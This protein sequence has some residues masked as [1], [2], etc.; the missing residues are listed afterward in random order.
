MLRTSAGILAIVAASFRWW[1][2]SQR[3][4]SRRFT[5][6]AFH[7][8]TIWNQGAELLNSEFAVS[9]LARTTA[10]RSSQWPP[11]FSCFGFFVLL[12]QWLHGGESIG[13][14]WI[15]GGFES[16]VWLCSL[17]PVLLI[18]W[19]LLLLSDQKGVTLPPVTKTP[20]L[21]CC[22][23]RDKVHMVSVDVSSKKIS[24]GS[25]PWWRHFPGSNAFYSFVS[26]LS[27]VVVICSSLW[28]GWTSKLGGKRS[29]LFL[30]SW[31]SIFRPL[32]NHATSKDVS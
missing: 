10:N 20:L 22:S 30:L 2:C 29:W 24:P 1:S 19:P 9:E 15:L 31:L 21:A 3:E 11:L 14:L 7:I 6:A 12:L 26:S 8:T 4:I 5:D 17:F 18:W 27:V 13:C 23:V 16:I 28:N 25:S 32:M